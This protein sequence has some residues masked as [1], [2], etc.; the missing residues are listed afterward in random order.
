MQNGEY[1][2]LYLDFKTEA[3]KEVKFENNEDA[4]YIRLSDY[5]YVGQDF[6]AFISH[7]WDNNDNAQSMFYLNRLNLKTLQVEPRIV[8]VKAAQTHILGV[9]ADGCILFWYNLNPS[10]NGVCLTK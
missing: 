5:S 3:I 10:E 6:A 4:G 2:T 8:S 1:Q 7:T 9:L